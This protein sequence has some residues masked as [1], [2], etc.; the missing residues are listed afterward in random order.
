MLHEK[1]FNLLM[2]ITKNSEYY[3][4]FKHLYTFTSYEEKVEC[5]YWSKKYGKFLTL[6]DN[7]PETLQG[8]LE[9]ED[10]DILQYLDSLKEDGIL[11]N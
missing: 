10:Q 5:V 11:L 7:F 6:Q 4:S 1:L 8:K 9:E 2:K 3:S